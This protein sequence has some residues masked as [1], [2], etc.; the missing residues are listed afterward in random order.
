MVGI[1]PYW[2]IVAS[3]S[4]LFFL[5]NVVK[6]K[7]MIG[8]KSLKLGSWARVLLVIVVMVLFIAF[9]SLANIFGFNAARIPPQD[10]PPAL[11]SL[12]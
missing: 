5:L 2:S 10:P 4:G 11:G 7:M 6:G 12:V 3:N 8:H 1:P 9:F